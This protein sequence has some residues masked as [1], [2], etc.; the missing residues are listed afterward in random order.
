MF[1]NIYAFSLVAITH[2]TIHDHT[3]HVLDILLQFLPQLISFNSIQLDS[4]WHC[5]IQHFL[6][7]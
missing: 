5:Y 7:Y 6:F 3:I 4:C 2:V 1:L